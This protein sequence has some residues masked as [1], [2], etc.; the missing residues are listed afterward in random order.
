MSLSVCEETVLES[1]DVLKRELSLEELKN[2][3]DVFL[4]LVSPSMPDFRGH[5]RVFRGHPEIDRMVTTSLYVPARNTQTHM[6]FCFAKEG[7]LVPHFTVDTADHGERIAFHLDLIPRRSVAANLD[8]MRGV[9]AP[10]TAAFEEIEYGERYG[11][12]RITPEQR[13]VMSPWML[14]KYA[15]LDVYPDI[16]KRIIPAYRSRFLDLLRSPAGLGAT[17]GSQGADV[18]HREALFDPSVDPVWPR[19]DRMVGPES[20]ARI[21]GLLSGQPL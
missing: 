3:G 17:H 10:L 12:V 16:M 14:V 19:L 2:D 9:Y 5:V 1:V 7:S 21:R 6:V 4:K 11:V 13:A 18:A 8:Y 20:S 15:P